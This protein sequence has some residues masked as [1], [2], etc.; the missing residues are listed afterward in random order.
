MEELD[1]KAPEGTPEQT[2][3]SEGSAE[4]DVQPVES[5]PALDQLRQEV[6]EWKNRFIRLQADFDNYR[7]RV[8]RERLEERDRGIE[9]VVTALFAIADNLTRAVQA[10]RESSDYA[11]LL[12]GVEMIN[13]QVTKLLTQF[14]VTPIE[15]L[16]QPF[17]PN[18]HHAVMHMETA[19][20]PNN[21]V[22]AELQTGYQRKGKV[23]RPSMVQ[24]A[25]NS[26]SSQGGNDDQ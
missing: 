16:N 22:I 23:L 15:A 5:E 14:E 4:A 11:S 18:L 21:T 12:K 8:S 3:P 26:A 1:Q 25:I 10:A 2:V 9:E 17:D 7:K 19:E 6:E 13:D 20:V 24:V